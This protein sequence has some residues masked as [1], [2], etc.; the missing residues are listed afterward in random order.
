M[1]S[2]ALSSVS[3]FSETKKVCIRVTIIKCIVY[4]WVWSYV[5]ETASIQTAF[6]LFKLRENT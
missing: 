3:F 2:I 6:P 5:S 4:S 1:Y